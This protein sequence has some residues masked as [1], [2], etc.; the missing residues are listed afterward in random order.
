ME[1]LRNQHVK[2]ER[3]KGDSIGDQSYLPSF[4]DVTRVVEYSDSQNEFR[5]YN[6]DNRPWMPDQRLFTWDQKE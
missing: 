6:T 2:T 3:E 1:Q 5:C 4:D